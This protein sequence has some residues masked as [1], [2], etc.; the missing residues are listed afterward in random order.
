MVA[1]ILA[2]GS[3]TRLRPLT[4]SRPKCMVEVCGH[5]LI[6]TQLEVLRR[7]GIR[8]IVVVGG[9]L[10]DRLDAPGAERLV[11]PDHAI[12]NMVW[13]LKKAVRA[14]ND[15]VV[16]SYGDI[17][18]PPHVLTALLQSPH[19]ISVAVDAGWRS[20]WEARFPD[21]LDDAE[22]L[23]LGRDGS[24]LEI[25]GRPGALDEIEGQ[26]IGLM[27]FR[28][29]EA[30]RV[31]D[32]LGSM[33]EDSSVN[34]KPAMNAYMTDF[35]QSLIDAGHRV[36]AV[37]FHGNWCEVDSPE[38]LAVAQTRAREWVASLFAGGAN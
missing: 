21:A 23:R 14:M 2:A 31:R 6:R 36:S 33:E 10:A 37:P 18:Y 7:C 1:I 11:S 8:N 32:L 13:T 29:E 9:Y 28:G 19:G 16:V 12:S 4:E 30:A 25:G 27:R 22:S 15:D 34:G 17:I 35:L 38:D 24:I 5:S 20:Y 26:Y 3:G